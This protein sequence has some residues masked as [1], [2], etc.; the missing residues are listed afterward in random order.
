MQVQSLHRQCQHMYTHTLGSPDSDYPIVPPD[1]YQVYHELRRFFTSL[2][3]L[4]CLRKPRLRVAVNDF[5]LTYPFDEQDLKAI[6]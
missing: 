2:V 5:F 3:T 6:S 1:H 4:S